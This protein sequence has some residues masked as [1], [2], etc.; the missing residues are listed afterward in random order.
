MLALRL[1]ET[2]ANLPV[3]GSSTMQQG[4]VP[5]SPTSELIESRP[6]ALS[7]VN[8]EAAPAPPAGITVAVP[9]TSPT[10]KC[11]DVSK[12]TPEKVGS[13]GPGACIVV[14][15]SAVPFASTGKT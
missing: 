12:V 7:T 9:K 14:G 13:A 3:M 10:S 11:P 8:D 15:A 4:A 2:Y 5:E 6:P 1:F